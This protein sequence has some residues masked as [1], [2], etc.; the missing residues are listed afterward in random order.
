MLT[1]PIEYFQPQIPI[2]PDYNEYLPN[3]VNAY[4]CA[5][6]S[7]LCYKEAVEAEHTDPNYKAG[8]K[9]TLV[10]WGWTSEDAE[11]TIF[12]N[13]RKI[14]EGGNRNHRPGTQGLIIFY[15]DNLVFIAFRG[16]EK[17]LN[18]WLSNFNLQKVTSPYIP[19]VEHKSLLQRLTQDVSKV[20]DEIHEGT[21]KVH[22][23]FLKAFQSLIPTQ[24]QHFQ[25]FAEIIEQ[26][27]NKRIWLTGHSLGGALAA[28]ATSYLMSKNIPIAG[29]YT[30]GSPRI[31]NRSYRTYIN[32]KLTYKYWR[33]GNDH[34]IVADIPLPGLLTAID[35]LATGF[36][37][38]GSMIRLKGNSY[39]VLRRIM[40]NGDVHRYIPYNGSSSSDHSMS[41]YI[42]GIR[43]IVLSKNTNFPQMNYSGMPNNI[44][45]DTTEQDI[46]ELEARIQS[47]K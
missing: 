30:F 39:E 32:Q 26:I 4:V 19:E 11:K 44:E 24:G 35:S 27:K 2:P 46:A 29:L 20:W 21:P 7:K 8:V 1:S 42:E 33:F 16:S 34:D 22:Q 43:Q 18:D 37:R 14:D 3:F 10:S 17:K 23:G 5:A 47:L 6:I 41:K 36:S 40:A 45:L 38:E 9:A 31:G 12:L 28:V 13:S 15:Q 25:T